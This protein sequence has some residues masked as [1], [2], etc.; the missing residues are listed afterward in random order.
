MPGLPPEELQAVLDKLDALC[1][2][3][4]ELQ[5]QI[6][7]QMVDRARRDQPA[8]SAAPVAERRKRKRAGGGD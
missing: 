7:K 5:R 2:Q 4:Q 6:R 1:Q 3:A 8:R